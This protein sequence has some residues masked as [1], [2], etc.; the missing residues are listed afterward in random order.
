[1]AAGSTYT[2]IA[3]TTLGSAASS[4]TF[5]SIPSSYTD[6]RIIITGTLSAA[7][8][9]AI[10]VGNGSVDT[11]SNY[12]STYLGGNGSSAS[13]GRFSN[14]V[15]AILG[16][17]GISN[18]FTAKYDFQNYSNT[19]TNKTILSRTDSSSTWVEA[20]VGLWRST[21]AINTIAVK[22]FAGSNFAIG[23]T[24]TLYGIAAA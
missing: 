7:D 2:P 17:I 14:T 10:Q 15:W 13:S 12:S 24:F 4:Y 21:S 6:L 18:Q 1:M 19:T 9:L 22:T 3:T 8:N 16:Y 23:T 11:G 20:G 5:T